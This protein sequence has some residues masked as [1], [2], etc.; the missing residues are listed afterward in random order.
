MHNGYNGYRLWKQFHSL[1]WIQVDDDQSYGP[2]LLESLLRAVG[3]APGRAIGAATQHH[4]W[5]W[6]RLF[7]CKLPPKNIMFSG[8]DSKEQFGTGCG[9]DSI[10]P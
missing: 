2:M 3:P 7:A 4:G 9:F 5:I 1:L 8:F 10:F 6:Q